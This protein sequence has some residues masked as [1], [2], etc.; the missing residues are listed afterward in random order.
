MTN[1]QIRM[2]AGTLV[3]TLDQRI[4]YWDIIVNYQLH[5]SKFFPRIINSEIKRTC[6]K[7]KHPQHLSFIIWDTVWY[8]TANMRIEDIDKFNTLMRKK[9]P[10]KD[11][12][13]WGQPCWKT[14]NNYNLPDEVYIYH[15]DDKYLFTDLSYWNIVRKHYKPSK[16]RSYAMFWFEEVQKTKYAPGGKGRADDLKNY[17]SFLLNM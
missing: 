6:I 3:G 9:F 14:D 4:Q 17:A 1:I 15:T 8:D 2:M 10:T 11:S 12:M 16:L 7:L 5:S 13:N